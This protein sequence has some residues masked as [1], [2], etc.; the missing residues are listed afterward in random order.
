MSREHRSSVRF[1][2]PQGQDEAVVRAGPRTVSA[3]IL[4]ASATGFLL[5]CP[6]LDAV[7]G[8]DLLVA[9]S[10]GKCEVR[11]AF[12]ETTD[13]E[14]R[15]GVE[16]IRDLE[17]PVSTGL[18]FPWYS[19]LPGY[20]Q[21]GGPGNIATAIVALAVMVGGAVYLVQN[22]PARARTH[23][24]TSST[25]YWLSRKLADADRETR[26]GLQR[27][28][29]SL[30]PSS[31][32]VHPPQS[33]PARPTSNLTLPAAEFDS[34]NRSSLNLTPEQQKKAEVVSTN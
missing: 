31:A 13:D 19:F 16:R 18:S 7:A 2:L 21:A 17:E 20:N 10:A 29:H 1:S 15:L 3:K 4:N 6:K 12:S 32:S 25:S 23:V 26:A 24:A 34:T 28:R 33:L 9:T 30:W 14:T 8:D 27:L 11:V 22:W 5:Q